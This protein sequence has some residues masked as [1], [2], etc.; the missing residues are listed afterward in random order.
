MQDITV[1]NYN[2]RKYP[3]E[4]KSKSKTACAARVT[5]SQLIKFC[6]RLQKGRACG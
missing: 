1:A 6:I 4:P 3:N 5:K 2:E